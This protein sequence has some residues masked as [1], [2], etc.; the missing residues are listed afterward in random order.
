[1]FEYNELVGE[2]SHKGNTIK[3]NQQMWPDWLPQDWSIH[4][5]IDNLGDPSNVFYS[6]AKGKRFYSKEDVI[7]YITKHRSYNKTSKQIWTKS[8][9]AKNILRDIRL[10]SEDVS[11][12][13]S[14]NTPNWPE[15]LPQD[16][17]IQR[18]HDDPDDVYYCSPDR[19][20]FRC[21]DDVLN[22]IAVQSTS[23]KPKTMPKTKQIRRKRK[24]PQAEGEQE[25]AGTKRRRCKDNNVAGDCELKL[26]GAP[27][28]KKGT[29][30]KQ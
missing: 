6:N 28:L 19:K 20:K 30:K 8:K 12:S 26:A 7:Q 29:R 23:R 21:K 18:S 22:H 11:T 17:S 2:N 15:W 5:N 9:K 3:V 4:Q 10:L 25:C 1:M 13:Y 14:N 27:L 16:W 24:I